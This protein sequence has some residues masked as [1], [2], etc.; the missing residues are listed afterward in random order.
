M[1]RRKR[2]KQRQLEKQ[3]R[4][5]LTTTRPTKNRRYENVFI[6]ECGGKKVWCMDR[7]LAIAIDAKFEG[8][9]TWY[10]RNR[11]KSTIREWVNTPIATVLKKENLT[12]ADG[13]GLETQDPL[14]I[15]LSAMVL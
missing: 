9:G 11:N 15:A 7:Q 3:R 6:I 8:G 12:R 14:D 5:E 2:R 1:S 10:R 13:R 4:E